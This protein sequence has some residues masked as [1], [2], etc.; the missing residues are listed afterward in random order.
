MLKESAER[1]TPVTLGLTAGKGEEGP[2]L[3][4]GILEGPLQ[5]QMTTVGMPVVAL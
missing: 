4:E 2:E 5:T 3:E 1:A